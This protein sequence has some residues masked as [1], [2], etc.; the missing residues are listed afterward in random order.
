MPEK[1]AKKSYLLPNTTG[2][3][4]DRL[5]VLATKQTTLQAQLATLAEEYNFVEAHL[6]TTLP[7]A[8]LD[9]AIGKRATARIV[10]TDVTSPKDWDKIRAY[11][12]RTK[13]WDLLHK[14]L[15]S[16]ACRERWAANKVIP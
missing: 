5:Y 15:S 10:K 12:V 1:I 11:I 4:V 13:A 7:V 16:T 14:R 6:L 9:G 8:K 2:A 3:C